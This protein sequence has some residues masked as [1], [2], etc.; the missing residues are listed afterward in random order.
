M[1]RVKFYNI[2]FLF[3]K[4]KYFILFNKNRYE[5]GI[6]RVKSKS[7]GQGGESQDKYIF[8]FFL[9]YRAQHR[10]GTEREGE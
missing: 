8:L 10:D 3:I 6:V 1:K 5:H 7:L 2:Y 9:F 4:F